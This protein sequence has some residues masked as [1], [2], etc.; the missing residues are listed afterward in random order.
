MIRILN[1]FSGVGGNRTLW[2]N[3]NVTAVE[4]NHDV[5]VC[6]QKRFHDDTIIEIDVYSWIAQHIDDGWDFIWA[7][8]P[9]KTHSRL[10]VTGQNIRLPDLRLYELILFFQHFAK[11]KWIVENV[12][13]YYRPLIRPTIQLDRHL[14]W[15]NFPIQSE[16]FIPR[17]KSL[18][19]MSKTEHMEYLGIQLTDVSLESLRDCCHPKLGEY[20]LNQAFSQRYIKYD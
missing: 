3:C 10:N 6:Y 1:L 17:C 8:P 12:I 5:A 4:L 11:C 7:S 19:N 18:P 20:L 15:S 16:R 9:C 2:K 14:F 13:P